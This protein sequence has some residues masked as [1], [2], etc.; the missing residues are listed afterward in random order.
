M[1]PATVN[2]DLAVLRRLLRIAEKKRFIARSPFAEV[3]FLEERKF[4]KQPYVVS[5]E[6]EDRILA[7]A[8]PHIRMLVILLLETGMRC[9]LEALSLK[10]EDVDLVTDSIRIRESKT[11]AGVRNLPISGR[12][13]SEL[14]RWRERIGPEFSAYVFPNM[15]TPDRPLKD[16]RRSWAKALRDAKLKFF[17]MY[18]L[19]HAFASRLSAAGMSDLF[20]AQM[21]GHSTPSILQTYAKV[22]DEYRRSAIHKLE[23]LRIAHERCKSSAPASVN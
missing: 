8:E 4:R 16:V 14:V 19:R 11:L 3:E 1:G 9:G 20:V 23:S 22:I 17:V 2:R 7:V 15:G 6:D 18:N 10:W 12:C 5:F 21:M 13:K